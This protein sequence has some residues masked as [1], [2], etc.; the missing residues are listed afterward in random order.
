[1]ANFDFNKFLKENKLRAINLVEITGYNKN[2]FTKWRT[3]NSDEKI[4]QDFILALLKNYPEIDLVKY[5]PTHA[6]IIKMSKKAT[7]D[8]SFNASIR[9]N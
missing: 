1:M 5:F 2:T 6:E 9:S 3:L 8:L 4:P 7:N